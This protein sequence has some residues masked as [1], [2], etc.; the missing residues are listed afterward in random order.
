MGPAV[1]CEHSLGWPLV[2]MGHGDKARGEQACREPSLTINY[3]G[4][5]T[6]LQKTF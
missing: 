3:Y 5:E 1:C 4:S 2:A 6:P